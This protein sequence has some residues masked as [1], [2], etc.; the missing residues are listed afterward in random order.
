MIGL[1]LHCLARALDRLDRARAE[2]QRLWAWGEA[3]TGAPGPE[4][5]AL[6]AERES[7]EHK[8]W[9]AESRIDVLREEVERWDRR[10]KDADRA[11]AAEVAKATKERDEIRDAA[12]ALVAALED[13]DGSVPGECVYCGTRLGTRIDDGRRYCDDHAPP[14]ALDLTYAPAWRRLRGLLAGRQP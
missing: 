6:R 1:A 14:D 8:L 12:R 11:S 2:A 9:E 4:C 13:D 10:H 7:L 3:F 5:D